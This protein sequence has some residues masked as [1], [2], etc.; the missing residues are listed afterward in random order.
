M[1]YAAAAAGL[2]AGDAGWTGGTEVVAPGAAQRGGVRRFRLIGNASD[3]RKK[4]GSVKVPVFSGPP[5]DR[6]DC[7][8]AIKPPK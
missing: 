1:G 5:R 8:R 6:A 7:E 4:T 3:A 2:G